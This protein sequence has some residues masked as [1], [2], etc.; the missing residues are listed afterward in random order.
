MSYFLMYATEDRIKI[1]QFR[2]DKK[3]IEYLKD[4]FKD[5]PIEFMRYIPEDFD[6]FYDNQVC[7]VNGEVAE[8]KPVEIVKSYVIE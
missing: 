5:S 6:C 1:K 7:V 2:T 4:H 8:P 3:L